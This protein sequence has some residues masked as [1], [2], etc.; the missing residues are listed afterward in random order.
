MKRI[1]VA[2]LAAFLVI[3]LGTAA[4]YFFSSQQ[5]SP[6]EPLNPQPPGAIPQSEPPQSPQGDVVKQ[7]VFPLSDAQKASILETV[8]QNE[9]VLGLK[10]RLDTQEAIVEENGIR[11]PLG[12]M[13]TAIFIGP[14]WDMRV[15]VDVERKEV[16]NIHMERH[17][18][19]SQQQEFQQLGTIAELVEKAE[20][21]PAV[22]QR[23]KDRK[24]ITR[25]SP[26][27]PEGLVD[28]G[29][30]DRQTKKPL[31]IAEVNT[32]S[33]E[34]SI[35]EIPSQPNKAV[36]EG[37]R[38]QLEGIKAWQVVALLLLAALVA[39]LVYMYYSPAKKENK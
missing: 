19:R 5:P 36:Q 32:K 15:S 1:L 17:K 22:A 13:G 35:R 24:Y 39:V 37:R 7:Q 2:V 16:V 30:I 31:F 28:V 38:A 4:L 29:F 14:E 27:T 20:Q 33:G 10:E 34:V 9:I 3:I 25:V 6:T 21:N 11:L 23:L 18:E 12:I 26:P 8:Q